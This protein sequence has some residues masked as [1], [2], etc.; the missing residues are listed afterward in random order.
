MKEVREKMKAIRKRPN[1]R[2]FEKGLYERVILKLRPKDKKEPTTEWEWG[3]KCWE[4]HN[5]AAVGKNLFCLRNRKTAGVAEA[6]Q[7]KKKMS[8]LRRD[9]PRPGRPQYKVHILFQ[10]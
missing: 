5:A 1:Y 9:N 10:V 2:L 8:R 3:V 4:Q 6:Q 7:E